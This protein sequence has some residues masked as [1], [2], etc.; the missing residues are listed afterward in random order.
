MSLDWRLAQKNFEQLEN[1]ECGLDVV[2]D[3]GITINFHGCINDIEIMG[4][5]SY[6]Q[7]MNTTVFRSEICHLQLIFK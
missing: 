7:D 3:L 4:K 6:I 2:G 5:L 1:F